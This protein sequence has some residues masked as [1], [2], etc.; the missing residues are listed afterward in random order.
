MVSFRKGTKKNILVIYAFFRDIFCVKFF[1]N[2]KAYEGLNCC[3]SGWWLWA[4]ENRWPVINSDFSFLR[5][6]FV[7]LCLSRNYKKKM[8]VFLAISTVRQKNWI[9]I[10]QKALLNFFLH[11]FTHYFKSGS[12]NCY[13]IE[14]QLSLKCRFP[15]I[16]RLL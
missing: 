10:L 12:W 3:L 16:Y 2:K 9:L 7:L 13:P 14:T 6:S 11:S 4:F 8:T 1:Q 15:S 5:N